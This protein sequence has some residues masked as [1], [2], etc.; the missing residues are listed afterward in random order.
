M[1]A[2]VVHRTFRVVAGGIEHRFELRSEGSRYLVF[3]PLSSTE[4]TSVPGVKATPMPPRIE[5][6]LAVTHAKAACA[7]YVSTIGPREFNER[8]ARVQVRQLEM[9]V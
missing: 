4:I 3:D 1:T 9:P 2:P 7:R 8:L 5:R 6:A